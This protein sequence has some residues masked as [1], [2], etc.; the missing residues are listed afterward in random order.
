MKASNSSSN[1]NLSLL[2]LFPPAPAGTIQSNTW[3]GDFQREN[4][5]LILVGSQAKCGEKP[6]HNHAAS[7]EAGNET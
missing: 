3:K 6:V 4:G 2:C 1:R 7:S 5:F